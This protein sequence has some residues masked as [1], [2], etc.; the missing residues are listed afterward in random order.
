M[1]LTPIWLYQ[2]AGVITRLTLPQTVGNTYQRGYTQGAFTP[3]PKG[4]STLT[5][6]ST[7]SLQPLHRSVS[8]WTPVSHVACIVLAT[9]PDKPV[10]LC[11]FI[12]FSAVITSGIVIRSTGPSFT[13]EET[14]WSHSFS[15]FIRFSIYFF[16]MSLIPFSYTTTLP[17]ASFRQLEPVTSCLSFLYHLPRYLKNI[18]IYI[19]IHRI[20]RN[21]QATRKV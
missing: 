16:H 17:V 13:L 9:S 4:A 12:L 1:R 2:S 19:F 11:F 3:N 21:I 14:S 8:H 20:G 15:S 5:T 6:L 18:I 7:S 10:T